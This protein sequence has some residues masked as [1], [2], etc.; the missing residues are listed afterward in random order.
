MKLP[1]Y[2]KLKAKLESKG[3]D[4]TTSGQIAWFVCSVG[5]FIPPMLYLYQD[6]YTFLFV[7][8]FIFVFNLFYIKNILPFLLVIFFIIL[9]FSFARYFDSAI[10]VVL[11]ILF[12]C[13]TSVC[14][15]ARKW[16]FLIVFC[17]GI[18]FIFLSLKIFNILGGFYK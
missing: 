4:P 17:F 6:Q 5:I 16:R 8:F 10:W 7:V 3:L 15:I 18:T 13:V 2:S 14:V 12:L 11:G 9:F 1:I